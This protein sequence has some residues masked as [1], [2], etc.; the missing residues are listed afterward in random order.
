M[1]F[2]QMYILS[3][4]VSFIFGAMFAAVL[5]IGRKGPER[6]SSAWHYSGPKFE[7]SKTKN[8]EI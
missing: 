6:K 7:V 1:S 5:F 3:N 8:H 4:V 2:L